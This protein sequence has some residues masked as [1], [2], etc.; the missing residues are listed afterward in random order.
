MLAYL[1]V[2]RTVLSPVPLDDLEAPVDRW[3]REAEGVFFNCDLD[4]EAAQESLVTLEAIEGEIDAVFEV[5][6]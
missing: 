4:D 1:R 2:Q 5:E 3:F 6:G